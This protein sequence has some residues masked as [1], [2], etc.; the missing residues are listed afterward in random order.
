MFEKK[1][2]SDQMV[3]AEFDFQQCSFLLELHIL[4]IFFASYKASFYILIN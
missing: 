3:D 2:M 4:H 1:S